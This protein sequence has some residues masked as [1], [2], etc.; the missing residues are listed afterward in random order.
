MPAP[1]KQNIASLGM[2]IFN[3]TLTLMGKPEAARLG[4]LVNINREIAAGLRG[5]APEKSAA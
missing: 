3:H 4:V 1:I 2:F 5:L